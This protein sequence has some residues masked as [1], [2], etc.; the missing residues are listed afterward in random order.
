MITPQ[1]IRD[2]MARIAF[3]DVAR[4]ALVDALEECG[5]PLTIE[6]FTNRIVGRYCE[7]CLYEHFDRVKAAEGWTP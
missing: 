6:C 7:H 4:M 5:Y 3:D 1:L 2:L